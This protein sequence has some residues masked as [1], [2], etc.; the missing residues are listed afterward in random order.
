MKNPTRPD[1]RTSKPDPTRN[2][3]KC[4][5]VRPFF[6]V[7]YEASDIENRICNSSILA[8]AICLLIGQC[9]ELASA[10]S[11]S[12]LKAMPCSMLLLLLY[13]LAFV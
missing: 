7:K 11:H 5:P 12:F 2:P 1:T 4:Y 13:A 3:K 9:S 6:K 10:F 8:A